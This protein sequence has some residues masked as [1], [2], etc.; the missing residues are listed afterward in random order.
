MYSSIWQ[1][2]VSAKHAPYVKAAGL[3]NLVELGGCFSFRFLNTTAVAIV[4]QGWWYHLRN[5]K[6][7]ADTGFKIQL[8]RSLISLQSPYPPLQNRIDPVRV[9]IPILFLHDPSK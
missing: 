7:A 2:Y 9:Q 3:K 4:I 5:Y 6:R 1:K 8:N